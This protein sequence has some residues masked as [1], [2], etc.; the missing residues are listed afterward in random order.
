MAQRRK[1]ERLPRSLP[2]VSMRSK[3]TMLATITT[4]RTRRS[5]FTTAMLI[6]IRGRTSITEKRTA[7]NRRRRKHILISSRACTIVLQ[8]II[9]VSRA[10]TT[11]SVNVTR[12]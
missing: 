10:R 8:R 5:P 1:A 7:V 9:K 2:T 6:I 12:G 3:T 4:D 11:N